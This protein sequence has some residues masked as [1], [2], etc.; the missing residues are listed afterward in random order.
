MFQFPPRRRGAPQVEMALQLTSKKKKNSKRKVVTRSDWKKYGPEEA[1]GPNEW[2]PSAQRNKRQTKSNTHIHLR[3]AEKS[4]SAPHIPLPARG[5]VS[6]SESHH[7]LVK[8][9]FHL[10]KVSTKSCTISLLPS[11]FVSI[12]Q[13]STLVADSGTAEDVGADDRQQFRF[14]VNL[15]LA[16]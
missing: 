5:L 6:G 13:S 4:C 10:Q 12:P 3:G 16:F 2:P 9:D 11:R 14:R 7:H 8:F 15:I 1:D